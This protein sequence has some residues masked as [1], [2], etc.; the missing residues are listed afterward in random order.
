M[1]RTKP[2]QAI[3]IGLVALGLL[4]LTAF[5]ATQNGVHLEAG[6]VK[7]SLGVSAETG[8][9]VKFLPAQRLIGG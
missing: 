5:S 8:L 9:S 1:F 7:L 6:G 3:I 2:A 4:G